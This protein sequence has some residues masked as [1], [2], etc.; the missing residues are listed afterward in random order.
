[1]PGRY[2]CSMYRV[3]GWNV[4]A[5]H[6][7][8]RWSIPVCASW[9]TEPSHTGV[10]HGVF[11]LGI[12]LRTLIVTIR[13]AGTC[14]RANAIHDIPGP[15]CTP[16]ESLPPNR[17]RRGGGRRSEWRG[18]RPD[19]AAGGRSPRRWCLRMLGAHS[20]A[21]SGSQ[22]LANPAGGGFRRGKLLTDSARTAFDLRILV[23]PR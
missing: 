10:S 12:L 3:L 19:G 6:S 23:N 20:V 14:G 5:G 13:G 9:A 17:E 16:T 7:M 22:L 15:G 1:M 8:R 11:V 18:N 4:T 2:T 21:L